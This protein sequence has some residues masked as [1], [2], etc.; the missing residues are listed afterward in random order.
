MEMDADSAALDEILA[1]WRKFSIDF[2]A[3]EVCH[4]CKFM[5][6]A[7]LARRLLVVAR[8]AHQAAGQGEARDQGDARKAQR[9]KRG[10]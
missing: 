9:T 7:E 5:Q 2:E 10:C 1:E 6:N 8:R 3:R 4:L